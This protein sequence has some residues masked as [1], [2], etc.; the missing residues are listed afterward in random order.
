M[1]TTGLH[2]SW[3]DSD[4]SWLET[5]VEMDVPSTKWNTRKTTGPPSRI[6]SLSFLSVPIYTTFLAALS[7]I[8]KE[9][10][11]AV[12]LLENR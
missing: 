10:A 9:D 4:V 5:S 1:I 3:P 11:I 2:K 6:I 12:T 8:V 7:P